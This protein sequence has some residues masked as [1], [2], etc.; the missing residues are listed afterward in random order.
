MLARSMA[1]WQATRNAGALSTERGFHTWAFPAPR[2]VF[3]SRKLTAICQRS[4]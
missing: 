2:M 3:S 1:A 4:R